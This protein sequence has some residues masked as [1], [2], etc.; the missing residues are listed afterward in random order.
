MDFS[1][2]GGVNRPL[3]RG[4]REDFRS[5]ARRGPCRLDLLIHSFRPVRITRLSLEHAS[6]KWLPSDKHHPQLSIFFPRDSR[7][8]GSNIHV[9]FLISPSPSRS[10]PRPFLSLHGIRDSDRPRRAKSKEVNAVSQLARQ[11]DQLDRRRDCRNRDSQLSDPI[12]RRTKKEW[13]ME[14]EE[15]DRG[16][17]TKG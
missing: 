6:K 12:C 14:T 8:G 4:N 7:S 9:D 1:D 3:A 16:M 5:R 2:A 15:E 17:R 10:L 13:R 11:L